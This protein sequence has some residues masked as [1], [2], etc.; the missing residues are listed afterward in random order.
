[1]SKLNSI[2]QYVTESAQYPFKP[3]HIH[4]PELN[5]KGRW[6]KGDDKA[7]THVSWKGV[8]VEQRQHGGGQREVK[9]TRGEKN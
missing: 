4:T 1:M 3:D 2:Q 7:D 8:K 5:R 9:V 6:R